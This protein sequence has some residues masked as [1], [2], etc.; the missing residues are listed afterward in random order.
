MPIEVHRFGSRNPAKLQELY[1][2]IHARDVAN[3]E[4]AVPLARCQAML[5]D[6]S[7]FV[8]G[9]R[10]GEAWVGRAVA[11][12]IR[13]WHR[14]KLFLYEIDVAEGFRQRGVG[15]RLIEAVLA[16]AR[17]R[18]LASTFVMTNRSNE[19]AMRLY[20]RTGAR[21]PNGDDLLLAW[22]DD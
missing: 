18:G 17:E 16:I 9:A 19:A 1:G 22:W 4:T 10:V 2:R 21:Q 3:G 20:R 5:E 15:T 14:D 12:T 7:Y 8:L 11:L 13:R 6:P